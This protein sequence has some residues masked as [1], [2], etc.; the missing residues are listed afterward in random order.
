MFKIEIILKCPFFERPRLDFHW[1][2]ADV[3]EI[4]SIYVGSFWDIFQ[5]N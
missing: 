4:S 2:A 3:P 5:D 1:R